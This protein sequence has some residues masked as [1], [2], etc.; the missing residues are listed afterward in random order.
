MLKVY[1]YSRSPSALVPTQTEY[2][3]AKPRSFITSFSAKNLR[4]LRSAHRADRLQ[5]GAGKYQALSEK[6]HHL[7]QVATDIE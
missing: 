7:S 2:E 1:S 4:I 5:A 3:H 6:P